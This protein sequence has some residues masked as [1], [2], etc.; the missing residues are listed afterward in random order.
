MLLKALEVDSKP[1]INSVLLFSEDKPEDYVFSHLLCLAEDKGGP[2]VLDSFLTPPDFVLA[3]ER[4]CFLE[5][6]TVWHRNMS[7]RRL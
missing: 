5:S 3:T 2:V 7:R 6:F 4:N 1:K